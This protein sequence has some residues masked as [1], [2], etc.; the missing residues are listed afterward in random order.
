MVVMWE[1]YDSQQERKRGVCKIFEIEIKWSCVRNE[2]YRR[3]DMQ[4]SNNKCPKILSYYATPQVRNLNRGPN[5]S[6]ICKNYGMIGH[7]IERCY[8]LIG[9]PLGFKMVQS[10]ASQTSSSFTGDQM[11]ELPSLINET[12]SRSIHA[13]MADSKLFVGFDKEKCYVHDLKREITFRTSSE[14]GGSYLFELD[15]DRLG[16]P[17]YQ[18]LGVLKN[19]LNI[20]RSSSVSSCE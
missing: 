4:T 19:D 2:S 20:S 12:H 13:N 7:A 17:A 14:Y 5:P 3:V 6:L 8:E 16:H 10:P 15:S 9:Y 18:V 11:K 1:M